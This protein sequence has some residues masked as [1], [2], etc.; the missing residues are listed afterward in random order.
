[1]AYIS[2]KSVHS[3]R[4]F[5]FCQWTVMF[6]FS[7]FFMK[8][9]KYLTY[10]CAISNIPLCTIPYWEQILHISQRYLTYN[11]L[12]IVFTQL[13][14]G[15]WGDSP[16]AAP[17]KNSGDSLHC[18][19][20]KGGLGECILPYFWRPITLE[21]IDIIVY[22]SFHSHHYSTVGS[23]TVGANCPWLRQL[24]DYTVGTESILNEIWM[25]SVQ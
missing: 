23:R 21:P 19:N 25:A 8:S 5:F 14:A 22:D 3:Y 13:P 6:P 20:T 2:G 24:A 10:L 12:G 11:G 4:I 17:L 16:T 18:H 15:P 9:N 1:M 7:V